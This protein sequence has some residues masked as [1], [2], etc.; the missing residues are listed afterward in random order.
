MS[1]KKW[2]SLFGFCLMFYPLQANTEGFGLGLNLEFVEAESGGFLEDEL[3]GG[4]GFHVG[5]E[6][7]QWNQWNLGV[8]Y[9]RL[10]GWNDIGD[11]YWAGEFKYNSQSLLATFRP[12]GWPLMLKAGLVDAEYQVLLQD[13]TQN[14]RTVDDTGRVYGLSL[15][16]G[17]ENMRVEFL[18][19]KRITIGN[20]HFRS[21]GITI[22]IFAHM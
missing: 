19:Y 4:F 14:L 2:L 3:D 18:D 15:V 11:M 1:Y 20:D 5:Y 16:W 8:Q 9:E 6:F 12:T 7:K 10:N 22:A 13:G 21:F 17:N